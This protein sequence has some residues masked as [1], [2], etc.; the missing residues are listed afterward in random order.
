[1]NSISASSFSKIRFTLLVIFTDDIELVKKY[2]SPLNVA[3]IGTLLG[4][5]VLKTFLYFDEVCENTILKLDEFG[6][7]MKPMNI[8]FLPF[9][10]FFLGK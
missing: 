5:Y 6:Y 9:L 3:T 4:L 2:N 8:A 7:K 1:M 10:V